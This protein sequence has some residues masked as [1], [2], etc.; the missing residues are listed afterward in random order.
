MNGAGTDAD[1]GKEAGVAVR[2]VG[3]VVVAAGR[4][5]RMGDGGGDKNFADLAGLPVIVRTLRAFDRHPAVDAIALVLRADQL[6]RGRALVAEHGLT[7]VVAI[8]PGGERRQDSARRGIEAVAAAG[9]TIVLIHDGARPL[10]DAETIGRGIELARAHGAAV[11]AAPVVDTVK[12]VDAERRVTGTPRRDELWAV[13]TP[14]CFRLEL[15]ARAHRAASADVTD[16]AALVEALGHPVLV[17][18]SP[19]RNLKITAPDDL[20]IAAALLTAAGEA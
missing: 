12:R 11:A 19:R 16:D 4:G 3:V 2:E 14:Q 7:R 10:V 9:C 5:T 1:N 18:P 17:Y 20:V 13:Q 6:D 8:C 15:L